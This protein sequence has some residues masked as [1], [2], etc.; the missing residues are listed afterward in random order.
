MRFLL[1]I[2][3]LLA[4]AAAL[5]VLSSR[6]DEPFVGNGIINVITSENEQAGCLNEA[7]ALTA[8]TSACATYTI[9]KNVYTVPY[10]GT[11]QISYEVS[12]PAGACGDPFK[13]GSQYEEDGNR[14]LLCGAGSDSDNSYWGVTNGF[15]QL[16]GYTLLQANNDN[17]AVFNTIDGSMPTGSEAKVLQQELGN[18]LATGASYSLTWTPK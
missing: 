13:S 3:T 4:T 5:P 10:W 18:T 12:S 8:D 2:P 7:M 15:N 17:I 1:T 16:I 11:T 14:I 9:V 6:D